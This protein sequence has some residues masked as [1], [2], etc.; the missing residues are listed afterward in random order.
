MTACS[1]RAIT[2]A[3]AAASLTGCIDARSQYAPYAGYKPPPPNQPW[4]PEYPIREGE[5][6]EAT[7]AAPAAVPAAKPA[8]A[9]Q[10][11]DPGGPQAAP[12]HSVDSQ[13]LPPVGDE[14]AQRNPAR[15]DGGRMMLTP[16]VWSPNDGD[17]PAWI[18]V[19]RHRRLR[20]EQ[21]VD[22]G[23]KKASHS[24]HETRS[25]RGRRASSRHHEVEHATGEVRPAARSSHTVVVHRGD[26]VDSIADQYGTTAEVI[27]RTNHL[28][29][30][31][32][33]KVGSRLKVPTAKT[34]VVRPGDTLYSIH[35]RF[36]VP[37]DAL[38]S[39]NGLGESSRLQ[40][41]QKLDLP[42][43]DVETPPPEEP[44]R[45]SRARSRA[46][47]PVREARPPERSYTEV[48]PS[49]PAAPPPVERAPV[50]RAPVERAPIERAPIE[51][52]PAAP[53]APIPYSALTGRAPASPPPAPAYAQPPPPPPPYPTPSYQTPAAPP[54]G[55]PS[56]AP[57]PP[58]RTAPAAPPPPEPGVAA[59][60]ADSQVAAAGRG[61]FIWPTTGP[62]LS[63][64][65]PMP[66]GQRNDGVDI[67]A[68]EGSPVRAAAAGDVVY[69]GNL[70]PGFGNL[71]LIKH[72]DGWVTAYAH[73][74]RTEVKIRDHVSQG[75]EIGE[76]GST[77]G[78][79]QPQLHFEIRY[80]PSPRDRA[81]P[82]DPSLVLPPAPAAP[83]AAPAG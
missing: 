17:Q 15:Y 81:R 9:V 73:L 19:A 59:G 50:E 36:D 76:V 47:P 34:Y 3:L 5:A 77:G 52:T 55:G 4:R 12:T 33:L 43:Q 42:S 38:K 7:S 66:G 75:T 40:P 28:R 78:V 46:E 29:H 6:A 49:A 14:P 69:A 41:G 53:A 64:F 57:L 48:P 24:R 26:T 18:E 79:T 65:G 39:L 22:T 71:V 2:I 70:V 67:A 82:I 74:S 32:D 58:V 56:S 25:S 11:A 51:R 72:E 80:A 61:R 54:A 27:L 23:K 10:P 30:P 63:G 21:D 31:R 1:I 68:P 16:L 35:R 60:P 37:V 20:P 45:S 8:P 83:A 44:S 13:S 62:V